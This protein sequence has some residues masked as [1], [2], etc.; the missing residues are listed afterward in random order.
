MYAA[1][2]VIYVGS[3]VVLSA[4]GEW[5]WSQTGRLRYD[6]G[7]AVT[8]VERWFPR[9]AYWEPFKDVYGNDTSRGN[10]QGYIYSPLIRLDRAWIHPDRAVSADVSPGS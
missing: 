1:L 2:P 9:W 7:L 4:C 6:F 10:L 5:R 3:Y 8:D